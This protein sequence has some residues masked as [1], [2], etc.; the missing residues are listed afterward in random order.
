MVEKRIIDWMVVVPSKEWK[1]VG[2]VLGARNLRKI[3]QDLSNFV[4]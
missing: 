3:S 2:V 4:T 1:G